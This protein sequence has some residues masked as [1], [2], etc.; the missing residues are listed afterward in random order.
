MVGGGADRPEGFMQR[1]TFEPLRFPGR[2]RAAPISTTAYEDGSRVLY[3]H[4][5]ETHRKRRWTAS[6]VRFLSP[7]DDNQPS[8]STFSLGP[9]L[10]A[11]DRRSRR[12]WQPF[13]GSRLLLMFDLSSVC[14]L[15]AMLLTYSPYPR[16]RRASHSPSGSPGLSTSPWWVQAAVLVKVP[17]LRPRGWAFF[18]RGPGA[19]RM[20]SC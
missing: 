1:S 20:R 6:P 8:S 11:G 2:A 19:H 16:A 3:P 17:L 5:L 13:G 10:P 9:R 15:L 18:S 12:T 14:S 4:E 7:P